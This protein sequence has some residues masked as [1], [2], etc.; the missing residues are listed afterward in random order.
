MIPTA[1]QRIKEIEKHYS[2]INSVDCFEAEQIPF[3]LKAFYS[4]REMRQLFH[5]KESLKKE[6]HFDCIDQDFEERMSK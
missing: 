4:M 1:L 5:A 6:D 2:E 3:I